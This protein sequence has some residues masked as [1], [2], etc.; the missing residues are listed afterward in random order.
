[1]EEKVIYTSAEEENFAKVGDNT[2]AE[3]VYKEGRPC[4]LLLRSIS[5]E[6]LLATGLTVGCVI[7]TI[8]GINLRGLPYDYQLGILLSTKKPYT[9][10]FLNRKSDWRTA[11]PGILKELVVD[12]DNLV[13]FAFYELV[14]GTPFG[15][16][17]AKSEKKTEKIRELLSNHRKLKA[18]LQKTTIL[19]TE[20]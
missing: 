14:K 18:V 9:L 10:T 4:E 13:K 3:V 7:S 6:S 16:E 1:V 5:D 11:F 8:N 19:Q 15:I 2:D 17:L 12:G 20:L